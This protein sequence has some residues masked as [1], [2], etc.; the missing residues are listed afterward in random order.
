ME[1]AFPG[2]LPSVQK[3]ESEL[4]SSGLPHGATGIVPGF[5]AVG[6]FVLDFILSPQFPIP[7]I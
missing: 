3:R 2:L 6:L 4:W 1:V 5:S 7:G